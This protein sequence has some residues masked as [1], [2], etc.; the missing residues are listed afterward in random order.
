MSVPYI[1]FSNKTLDDKPR[2]KAGDELIC[3]KCGGRHKLEADDKGGQLL[4]FYTCDGNV[5]LGAIA[6]K[7]VAGERPDVSGEL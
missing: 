2:V 6:G 4:L 3:P 1:G 7:L 5:C